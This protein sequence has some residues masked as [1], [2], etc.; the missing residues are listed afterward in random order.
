MTQHLTLILEGDAGRIGI[1]DFNEFDFIKFNRD[2]EPITQ[3][4]EVLFVLIS[5]N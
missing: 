2:R 1:H 4:N 3:Q 5:H